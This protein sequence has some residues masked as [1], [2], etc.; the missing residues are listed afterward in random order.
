M[1]P[2]TPRLIAK[3]IFSQLQ[4]GEWVL[5]PYAVK[6]LMWDIVDTK[7]QPCITQVGHCSVEL[8]LELSSD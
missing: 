4:L 6:L 1:N 2:S 5:S 7:R 3:L 8:K